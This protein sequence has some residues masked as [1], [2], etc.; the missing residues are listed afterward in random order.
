MV[1]GVPRLPELLAYGA[2]ILDIQSELMIRT[3]SGGGLVS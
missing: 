1:D 2:V 3:V